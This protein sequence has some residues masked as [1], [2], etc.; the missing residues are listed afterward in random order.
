MR[1]TGSTAGA[2]VVGR[3]SV[4]LA[5]VG[6]APAAGVACSAG[7][8]GVLC[9]WGLVQGEV[10]NPLGDVFFAVVMWAS[11]GVYSGM[12]VGTLLGIVPTVVAVILWPAME[13]RLGSLRSAAVTGAAVTV[14]AALEVLGLLR[15]GGIDTAEALGWSVGAAGVAGVFAWLFLWA[16]AWACV[17]AV[18]GRA[19]V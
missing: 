1:S 4:F 6:A 15:L 12:A 2:T 19:H 18:G 3:G 8:L 17:P 10:A 11:M 5:A 14:I 7:Y 16:A 13:S 9:L